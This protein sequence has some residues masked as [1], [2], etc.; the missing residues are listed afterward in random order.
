[1]NT[2]QIVAGLIYIVGLVVL[3]IAF[4][5]IFSKAGYSAL[6]CLT[7]LVPLINF[8]VIIWFAFTTWPIERKL[9]DLP[10]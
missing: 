5:K 4:A 3:F 2:I 6:M 7:L 9:A 8:C 1:M 10:Q